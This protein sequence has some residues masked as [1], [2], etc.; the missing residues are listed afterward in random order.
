MQQLAVTLEKGP[1]FHLLPYGK[2]VE[3]GGG[4]NYSSYFMGCKTYKTD[5]TINVRNK[6]TELNSVF[7]KT[8]LTH[9]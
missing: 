1:N 7:Q 6:D 4:E 8:V 5:G 9:K 2:K 3:V